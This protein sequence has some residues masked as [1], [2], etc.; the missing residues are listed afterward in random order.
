MKRK[1]LAMIGLCV[2]SVGACYGHSTP[3]TN[4]ATTTDADHHYHV[5][6]TDQVKDVLYANHAVVLVDARTKEYDDGVRLPGAI[7]LPHNSSVEDIRAALPDVDASIIVYCTG[8]KCPAS[9]KLV[10]RLVAMNYTHVWKYT[11][12]LEA[13]IKAGGKTEQ[14]K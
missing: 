10:D 14:V 5:I 4:Q 13:W 1:F 7:H 6:D 9:G 3:N 12:G 2:L 8:K 11:D